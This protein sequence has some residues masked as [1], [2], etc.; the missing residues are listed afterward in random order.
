MG[1]LARPSLLAQAAAPALGAWLIGSAGAE[2]TLGL[3]AALAIANAGVLGVL[4]SA[5]RRPEMA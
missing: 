3:I 5:I 4:W 1:R 2:A